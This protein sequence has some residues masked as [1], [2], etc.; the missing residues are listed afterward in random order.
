MFVQ[1]FSYTNVDCNKCDVLLKI[2]LQD[3]LKLARSLKHK[4]YVEIVDLRLTVKVT[5]S[6]FLPCYHKIFRQ[7][8]LEK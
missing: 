8:V 4:L 5:F 6:F 2:F 1:T 7:S 3:M